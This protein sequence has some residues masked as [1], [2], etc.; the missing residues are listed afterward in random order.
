LS[1]VFWQV[2]L[3]ILVERIECEDPIAHEESHHKCVGMNGLKLFVCC[4][5]LYVIVLLG[6]AKLSSIILAIPRS[7]NGIARMVR[8]DCV[9]K[10]FG[11]ECAAFLEG[12]E[13]TLEE[14]EACYYHKNKASNWKALSLDF[15][16]MIIVS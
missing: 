2:L 4:I 16:V 10:L 12:H 1:F 7:S 5:H 9:R 15:V 6:L 14:K 3:H 13:E 8:L 11:V